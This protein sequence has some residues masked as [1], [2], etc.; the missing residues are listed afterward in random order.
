[1]EK[2]NPPITQSQMGL[3]DQSLKG[4]TAGQIREVASVEK[5]KEETVKRC[6]RSSQSPVDRHIP[7]FQDKQ[8]GVT[9]KQQSS[10]ET[11][12]CTSRLLVKSQR[13]LMDGFKI[14]QQSK[15]PFMVLNHYP[16]R[17]SFVSSRMPSGPTD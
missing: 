16:M 8:G 6:I 12:E 3:L 13:G 15:N 5:T 2:A 10:L 7:D 9:Y 14:L 4:V 1:M 11:Q 17:T